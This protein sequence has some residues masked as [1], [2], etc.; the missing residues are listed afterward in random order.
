L[1]ALDE[2]KGQPTEQG[3]SL[4]QP[5]AICGGQAPFG[6]GVRLLRGE[7][8]KWYCRDHRPVKAA[9]PESVQT[10]PATQIPNAKAAAPKPNQG[11]L[12]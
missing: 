6:V 2:R 3:A 7:I 8:G 1:V 5:C 11:K 4:P 10:K 12:L 9:K